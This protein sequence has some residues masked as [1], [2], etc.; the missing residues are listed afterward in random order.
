MEKFPD[1]K[2][3]YQLSVPVREAVQ[4]INEMIA[5]AVALN[6]KLSNWYDPHS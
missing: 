2:I 5:W 3:R 4:K 6:V 1:Q